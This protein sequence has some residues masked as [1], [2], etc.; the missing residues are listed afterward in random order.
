M[1]LGGY[2]ICYFSIPTDSKMSHP[3]RLKYIGNILLEMRTKYPCKTMVYESGFSRYALS[4]QAIY[5]T[6][7]VISYI[8]ADV[9]QKSFAPSTVRKVICNNGRANKEDVKKE[10]LRRYPN[11]KPANYDETDALGV[12]ICYFISEGVK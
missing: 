12:G 1:D 5:K 3:Q 11:I 8:F 9:E 6:I 10:V 2:P 7:G 4:T